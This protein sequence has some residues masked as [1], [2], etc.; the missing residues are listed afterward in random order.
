MRINGAVSKEPGIIPDE[1]ESLFPWLSST[2]IEIEL[3]K[4]YY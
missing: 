1:M 3:N 4:V 2:H